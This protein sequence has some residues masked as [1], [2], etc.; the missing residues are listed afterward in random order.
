MDKKEF[1]IKLPNKKESV[2]LKAEGVFIF[3][4]C[5][6][7]SI[8]SFTSKD[9]NNFLTNLKKLADE[10]RIWLPYQFLEEFEVHRLEKIQEQHEAYTKFKNIIDNQF[11][12]IYQDRRIN[13]FGNHQFLKK[14][15]QNYIQNIKK[16][17]QNIVSEIE[18]A[19]DS[20]PDWRIDDPVKRALM[21]CFENKIGDPYAEDNERYQKIITDGPMRYQKFVPPGYMDVEKNRTDTTKKKQFG[22]LIA[23]F[24]IMDFAKIFK[25]P[26]AIVT[27]DEKEDWWNKQAGKL[28][29][30]RIELMYEIFEYA[31]VHL[32]MF[33][34]EG[35]MKYANEELKF[36][37][38]KGLIEKVKNIKEEGLDEQSIS[39]QIEVS[40]QEPV[41]EQSASTPVIDKQYPDTNNEVKTQE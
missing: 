11:Q 34:M 17:Q 30:P 35:F 41:V 10:N 33:N 1:I 15:K 21:K 12:T 40:A 29:G 22:D 3:D 2:N 20:H 36:D 31:G 38:N 6:L 24:Q 5:S 13:D 23:W 8:Y 18:A 9:R 27:I 16:I 28:F 14:Y 39:S 4:A 26:I 19:K 32:N 25:K 7:L 37:I